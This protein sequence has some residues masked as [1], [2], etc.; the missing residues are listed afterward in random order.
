[1]KL[2]GAA[3]V[4]FLK[5]MAAGRRKAGITIKT[6]TQKRKVKNV[7]KG[8]RN[9]RRKARGFLSNPL[10][11]GFVLTYAS[12]MLAPR[13]GVS[14]GIGKVLGGYLGG[15]K[16]IAGSGLADILIARGGVGGITGSDN[17]LFSG[18]GVL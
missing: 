16:Q 4:A 6:K 13:A 1:M 12:Y 11:K 17:G 8:K 7:A 15:A 5:R 18:D 2:T 3:K 9:Y 10:V 14:P